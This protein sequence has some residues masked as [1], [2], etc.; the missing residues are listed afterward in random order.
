MNWLR[1]A[2]ELG[3]LLCRWGRL[4]ALFE[5]TSS[6]RNS[7]T[8]TFLQTSWSLTMVITL[9]LRRRRVLG[10]HGRRRGCCLRR[11]VTHGGVSDGLPH[12]GRFKNYLLRRN[13][14]AEGWR[15]EVRAV[16]RRGVEEPS[17]EKKL[18]PAMRLSAHRHPG[19]TLRR[20]E[21]ATA[22]AAAPAA[23]AALPW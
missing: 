18:K 6:N 8:S 15:I 14:R 22:A 2:F 13:G 12:L 10:G 11:G 7:P 19:P 21:W 17:L 4:T 1:K 9:H 23:D 3:L 16:A 5:V 20:W